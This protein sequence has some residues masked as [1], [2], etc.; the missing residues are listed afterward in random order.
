MCCYSCRCHVD[1][2]VD[3][4][5]GAPGRCAFDAKLP[6]NSRGE[7]PASIQC[8]HLLFALSFVL[9]VALV[10][11][12]A[13]SFVVVV[14]VVVPPSA[15]ATNSH[16]QRRRQSKVPS[17]MSSSLGNDEGS[18]VNVDHSSGSTG[19]GRK[20]DNDDDV[21]IDEAMHGTYDD[22]ASDTMANIEHCA[23]LNYS[24]A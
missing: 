4:R 23:M 18:F 11:L 6:P 17:S 9:V 10:A 1:S 3:H 22:L 2:D 15:A 5:G 14:V 24:S 8:R 20:S 12:L 7:A 13:E 19:Q 16:H 21:I